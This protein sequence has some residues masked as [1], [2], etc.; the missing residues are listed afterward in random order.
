MS[1]LN[2]GNA[3]RLR[4]LKAMRRGPDGKMISEITW[5]PPKG[6]DFIVLILGTAKHADPVNPDAALREMGWTFEP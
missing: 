6:E 2:T 1:G 5:K 4:T 3:V